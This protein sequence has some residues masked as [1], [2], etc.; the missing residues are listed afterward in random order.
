MPARYLREEAKEV[1]RNVQKVTPIHKGSTGPPQLFCQHYTGLYTTIRGSVKSYLPPP[2]SPP[3]ATNRP[4]WYLAKEGQVY[5]NQSQ[6]KQLYR[7]FLSTTNTSP[8]D[9]KTELNF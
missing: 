9:S 6:V 3:V 2:V 7:L 8:H 1:A 5:P 4:N